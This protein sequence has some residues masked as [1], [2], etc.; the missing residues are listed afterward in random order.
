MSKL[1]R[2]YSFNNK[3]NSRHKISPSI[4]SN[5]GFNNC[6][7]ENNSA[8]ENTS[9]R[10]AIVRKRGA[11]KSQRQNSLRMGIE[12][13]PPPIVT[14][15]NYMSLESDEL[16]DRNIIGRRKY[17]AVKMQSNTVNIIIVALII[18]Y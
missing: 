4:G 13:T 9:F 10:T 5:K 17:L 1:P 3:I 14:K 2:R 8:D 12:D 16:E 7:S 18:T 11:A 6:S 15:R